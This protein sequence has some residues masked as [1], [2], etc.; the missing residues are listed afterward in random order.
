[1]NW[2]KVSKIKLI[3]K[4]NGDESNW[5]VLQV[6][7]YFLSMIQSDVLAFWSDFRNIYRLFCLS[8]T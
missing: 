5:K 3:S 4:R 2:I 1:M 6:Q 8:V 7:R